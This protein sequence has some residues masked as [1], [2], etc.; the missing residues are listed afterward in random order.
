MKYIQIDI[1]GSRQAI[2]PTIAALLEI[3]ITDVMGGHCG[4]ARKKERLR[5]GLY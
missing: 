4:F 5:L 2:E 3:G 1:R